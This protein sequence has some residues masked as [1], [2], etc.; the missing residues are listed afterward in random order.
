MSTTHTHKHFQL[1]GFTSKEN[2]MKFLKSE[3]L[4][5]DLKLPN[6]KKILLGLVQQ[7]DLGQPQIDLWQLYKTIGETKINEL[8]KTPCT[9]AGLQP[10]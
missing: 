1:N 10:D 3:K 9:C 6:K 5:T 2:Y 4:F 7:S 8:S